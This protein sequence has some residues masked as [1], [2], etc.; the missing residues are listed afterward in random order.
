MPKTRLSIALRSVRTDAAISVADLAARAGVTESWLRQVEGGSI[1]HPS[2]ERLDRVELALA[3][4]DGSL[5]ELQEPQG[6]PVR[7]RGDGRGRP[8][9]R[10]PAARPAP[11][12]PENAALVPLVERLIADVATVLDLLVN[13]GASMSVLVAQSEEAARRGDDTGDIT[14][15]LEGMSD[16]MS[17]LRARSDARAARRAGR[18]RR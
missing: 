15:V 10:R 3:L 5:R 18:P 9:A 4:P 6:V 8:A 14:A 17:V 2:V 16:D 12:D 1:P 13:I 7:A 11:A